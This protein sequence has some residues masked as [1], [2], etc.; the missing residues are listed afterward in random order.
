MTIHEHIITPAVYTMNCD[1]CEELTPAIGYVFRP[2]ANSEEA[3]FGFECYRCEE[4]EA[5]GCF[6]VE[7]VVDL[8]THYSIGHIS[9]VD[10]VDQF[11]IRDYMATH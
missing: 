6:K 7:D 5:K 3:A 9:S 11:F 1:F 2:Q 4:V 10:V 8:L